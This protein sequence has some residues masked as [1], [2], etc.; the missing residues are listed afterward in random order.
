[1]SSHD[2]MQLFQAP[3]AQ[4]GQLLIVGFS[5]DPSTRTFTQQ[6]LANLV[7]DEYSDSERQWYKPPR[8]PTNQHNRT[9]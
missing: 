1:V 2:I 6:V 7:V 9:I 5:F 4:T 3:T 8:P